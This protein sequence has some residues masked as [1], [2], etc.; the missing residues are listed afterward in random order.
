MA[1][2]STGESSEILEY[3]ILEN[4]QSSDDETNEYDFNLEVAD[5]QIIEVIHWAMVANDHSSA[6][7]S[8]RIEGWSLGKDDNFDNSGADGGNR[9]GHCFNLV[10]DPSTTAGVAGGIAVK[11][12]NDGGANFPNPYLL[13]NTYNVT[14]NTVTD[15]DVTAVGQIYQKDNPYRFYP[16][17]NLYLRYRQDDGDDSG[18]N[19][20]FNIMLKRT[21]LY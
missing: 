8:V 20:R 11:Y 7:T 18:D 5:N 10:N 16:G 12:P 3:L 17:M 21:T 14:S 9:F 19:F 1:T 15:N 6:G 13:D 4:A 2:Y